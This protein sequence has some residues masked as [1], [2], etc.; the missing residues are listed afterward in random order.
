MCVWE[1]RVGESELELGDGRKQQMVQLRT[2]K[3]C[4]CD[5]RWILS[6]DLKHGNKIQHLLEGGKEHIKG[7]GVDTRRPLG[8]YETA[9]RI[10]AR[11]SHREIWED[12]GCS[13]R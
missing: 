6:D 9:E 2:N 4:T 1:E 8:K 7:D 10:W 3:C 12:D 13:I 11:R 5:Q